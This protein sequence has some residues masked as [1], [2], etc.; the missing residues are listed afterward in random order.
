MEKGRDGASVLPACRRGP[1]QKSHR[2]VPGG[3]FRVR[4]ADTIG[5]HETPRV[6]SGRPDSNRGPPAPKAPDR[7][8]VSPARTLLSLIRTPRSAVLA[9]AEDLDP[10]ARNS[11]DWGPNGGHCS[12]CR[13]R[14]IAPF[15]G[16]S[17]SLRR[18]VERPIRP[19]GS[20]NHWTGRAN[21][22]TPK[23]RLWDTLASTP[24][25]ACSFSPRERTTLRTV[26]SRDESDLPFVDGTTEARPRPCP[27]DR[28]RDPSGSTPRPALSPFA[29]PGATSHAKS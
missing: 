16:Q 9:V 21:R 23:H 19:A 5:G 24:I 22:D 17:A 29:R 7:R 12:S 26:S 13:T 3:W 18:G 4:L 28:A 15:L 27:R 8:R 11:G 10:S 25:S 14:S 1:A 6:Q 20:E 2:G